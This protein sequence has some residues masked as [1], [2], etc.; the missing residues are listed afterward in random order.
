MDALTG[1]QPTDDDPHDDGSSDA[2]EAAE[3]TADSRQRRQRENQA[4]PTREQLLR[5]L[6]ALPRMLLAGVITPQVANAMTR[7]LQALLR[8]LAPTSN[9]GARAGA[10]DF[11]VDLWRRALLQYPELADDIAQFFGQA[12]VDELFGTDPAE[13]AE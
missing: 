5:M 6:H 4:L 11:D 10:A 3:R 12:D 7:T 9:G 1:P 13:G 8:E 2:P